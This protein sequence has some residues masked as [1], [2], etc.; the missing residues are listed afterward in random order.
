M[1]GQVKNPSTKIVFVEED[2]TTLN[3]ARWMPEHN[4]ISRRHSGRSNVGMV[5]GHVETVTQA[6]AKEPSH[7]LPE[8]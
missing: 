3:D 5:D 1:L 4:L 7:F 8:Y 2:R 6:F